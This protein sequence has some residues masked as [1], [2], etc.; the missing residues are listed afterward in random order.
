MLRKFYFPHT[1]KIFYTLGKF[2]ATVGVGSIPLPGSIF[3]SFCINLWSWM[4]SNAIYDM[5]FGGKFE[6]HSNCYTQ[7]SIGCYKSHLDSPSPSILHRVKVWHPP[8]IWKVLGSNPPGSF[9]LI[10]DKLNA[11]CLQW[12]LLSEHIISMKLSLQYTMIWTL[13]KNNRTILLP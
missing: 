13:R 4:A 5:H 12:L 1:W 11:A 2:L 10:E 9:L 3:F 7:I 6:I 8:H